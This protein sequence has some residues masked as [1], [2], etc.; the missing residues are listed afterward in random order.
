MIWLDSRG[1]RSR[2]QLA[3]KVAK[4]ST[5]TLGRQIHLLQGEPKN[6]M[7]SIVHNLA[8]VNGRKVYDMSKVFRFCLEKSK[9]CMSDN[10]NILCQICICLHYTSHYA[11]FDN[12]ALILHNFSLKHAVNVT[13]LI[14]STQT[15]VIHRVFVLQIGQNPCVVVKLSIISGVVK[16]YANFVKK[17]FKFSDMQVFRLFSR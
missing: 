15:Y 16:I 6:G 11:E 10:L 1:Q 9:T 5:S 3:V 12:N 14:I 17:I 8:I 2:S 13:K 4:P 7:F